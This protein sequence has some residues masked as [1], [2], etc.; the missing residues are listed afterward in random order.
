MVIG[1]PHGPVPT[2][3][4]ARTNQLYTLPLVRALPGVTEQVPVPAP[5]PT[6]LGEYIALT[7]TPAVFCTVSSY[8]V[9]LEIAFQVYVG[10]SVVTVPVGDTRTGA[11]GSVGPTGIA[12]LNARAALNVLEPPEFVAFPDQLYDCPSVS[13]VDGMTE[14]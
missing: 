9:A 8:D 2:L 3:L 11:P 5:H 1:P 12:T 4:V 7:A 13:A 6:A 14:Q 10:A